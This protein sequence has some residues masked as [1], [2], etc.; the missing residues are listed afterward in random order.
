[1][2]VVNRRTQIGVGLKFGLD[3]VPE[4]N[5]VKV[6]AGMRRLSDGARVNG[7]SGS[8]RTLGRD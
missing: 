4:K 6:R 5:D 8:C 1:M 7:M 2:E 3:E